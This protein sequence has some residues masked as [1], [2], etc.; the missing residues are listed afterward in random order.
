MRSH[1]SAEEGG[2]MVWCVFK[3]QLV[4]GVCGARMVIILMV[5][6]ILMGVQF[7]TT[8]YGSFV[9]SDSAPTFLREVML[10]SREGTGFG[11]YLF[12]LPLLAA[13]LGGDTVAV[14]RHSG[15]LLAL[16]PRVGRRRLIRTSMAS[17]FLL[18]GLGG[19]M[20]LIVNLCVAAAMIPHLSFINGVENYDSGGR[21]VL[22]SSR[23]WAYPLYTF[24]QPLLIGCIIALVFVVAG[25]YAT[26]AVGTSMFIKRRHVEM[27]AS[28]TL[29]LV[30]WMLP[31]LTGGLV[32]DQWSHI[33]FL[34]FAPGT[35]PVLQRQ[36]IIGMAL[37]IL[38]AAAISL[39]LASLEDRRDVI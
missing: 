34:F 23:S 35:S 5:S 13:L 24:S 2:R 37:T 21:Y 25:L 12:L 33:I 7:W 30:W 8:H 14:E 29:S 27:L 22:I 20:P 19:A 3:R 4:R 10:F 36:N 28:F 6:A 17:G 39:A 32:P 38:L 11:L 18:G 26:I 9:L 15:R 31:T 16:L 1:T